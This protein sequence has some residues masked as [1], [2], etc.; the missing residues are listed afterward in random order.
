[1]VEFKGTNWE[2]LIL[3]YQHNLNGKKEMDIIAFSNTLR[4][5]LEKK[6]NNV[7]HQKYFN[8]YLEESINPMGLRIQIFP[9]LRN[10]NP[11][12]KKKW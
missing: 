11:T 12:L 2:S 3:R 9:T 4:N 5:L 6:S 8:K 7:W 1:M 10:I